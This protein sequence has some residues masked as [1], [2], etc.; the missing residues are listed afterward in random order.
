[1]VT[2]IINMDKNKLKTFLIEIEKARIMKTDF[3]NKNDLELDLEIL[4][5]ELSEIKKLGFI[6][7]NRNEYNVTPKG[8]ELIKIGAIGGVFDF[9][10][11]GHIKTLYAAKSRCDLLVVIIARNK[12]V[13]KIKKRPPINDENI[14]KEIVSSLKLV[15]AAILGDEGAYVNPLFHIE[16]DEIYLGYDQKLLRQIES[17]DGLRNRYHV[18]QL[19]A[20]V[21]GI[22]TSSIIDR[23]K[24]IS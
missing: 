21:K 8:R 4:K 16:P 14:R 5:N 19:N 1:V 9:I 17:L 7:S 3:I 22:K 23:I 13:L 10:H 6:K 2:S 15:D 18:Y 20:Y 24:K 11:L 12:T